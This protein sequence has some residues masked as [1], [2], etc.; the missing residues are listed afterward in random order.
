MSTGARL[1][2]R[3]RA[4][5]DGQ[6]AVRE[7]AMFGGRAIMVNEN[8]LVSVGGDGSLLA[9][10]DPDRTVELLAIGGARQAEMAG[11]SMGPSWIRVAAE[12]VATDE[13]LSFWLDVAL[14]YNR[15][16][17]TPEAITS[18][19]TTQGGSWQTGRRADRPSIGSE[20]R[21]RRAAP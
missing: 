4:A 14:T 19:R 2:E 18:L 12:Q 17:T 8:L 6:P 11:R 9:R 1:A 20:G 3:V 10:I 13:G 15:S 21:H 5:L 7:V 16:R